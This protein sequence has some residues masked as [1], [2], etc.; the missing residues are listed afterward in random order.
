[1]IPKWFNIL[2]WK[3][4]SFIHSFTCPLKC[5][6]STRHKELYNLY[7]QIERMEKSLWKAKDS[8]RDIIGEVCQI[9]EELHLFW[10]QMASWK[11][12]RKL[13]IYDPD[14]CLQFYHHKVES[15]LV[16]DVSMEK[17]RAKKWKPPSNEVI[18]AP[19]SNHITTRSTHGFFTYMRSLFKYFC[20]NHAC[21]LVGLSL[22]LLNKRILNV[23]GNIPVPR[24][25][26]GTPE[27]FNQYEWLK[28]LNRSNIAQMCDDQ[29]VQSENE[30]SII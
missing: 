9:K 3:R 10:F 12:T 29:T 27:S 6:V 26:P 23:T 28:W 22:V 30:H 8:R 24:T 1:M 14:L 7:G 13:R 11:V 18:W 2:A 19:E 21:G 17:K 16:N 15:L 5:L 4:C 20:L 25:I